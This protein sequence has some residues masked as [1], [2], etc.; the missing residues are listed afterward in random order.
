MIDLLLINYLLIYGVAQNDIFC[1]DHLKVR[2]ASWTCDRHI[3]LTTAVASLTYLFNNDDE[4]EM[5]DHPD[6][7]PCF[8]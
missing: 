4:E 5:R 7:T 6:Q 3:G 2:W 8:R 1:N